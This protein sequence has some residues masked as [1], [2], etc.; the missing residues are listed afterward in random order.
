MYF[1]VAIKNV[2]KSMKDYSIYF[3]TLTIAVAIFYS[4][5]SIESQKALIEIKVSGKPYVEL[6]TQLI[7]LASIFVLIILTCL[8]VYA[9]NFLIKKR[10]KE[11]GIYMSLGMSKSKISKIL[12]FETLIIGIISLLF[13]ILLGIFI[14]Q[15]VS[16]IILNL[17]E[18][19]LKEFNFIISIPSIIKSIFSFSII[20]LLVMV[21]NIFIISKYKIIELINI[22]KKIE[23][24]KLKNPIIHL[25]IFIF[26]IICLFFAYKLIL[27]VGL[28]IENIKFKISIILGI[29]G[30]FLFFYSLSGIFLYIIKKSKFIYFKNL[31]IFLLK[32]I[33]SK[34]K[35]NFISMSI[36]CLMLFATIGVLS[37]GF[38]LKQAVES[39]LIDSTPF[40]A[41]A[42]IYI[43]KNDKIKDLKSVFNKLNFEFEK[44][45]KYVFF[46][47]YTNNK[48]IFEIIPT[49]SKK[50]H[51]NTIFL[52]ISEYNKIRKLNN[53]TPINL[54][55]NEILITSNFNNTLPFIKEYYKN[56]KYI[57]LGNENYEIKD[58]FNESL[59]TTG[60]KDN[61]CTIIINDDF[62]ENLDKVSSNINI[63]FANE[64]SKTEENLVKL[65]YNYS[66]LKLDYDT[67]GFLLGATK[68]LLYL[69]LKS[70]TSTVLF[71]GIYLGII[72]LISSMTILAL[73]QL[74]EANDS[75]NRYLTLKKIGANYKDIEKSIFFQTLIY[76][77]SP[78]FLAVIHS[79][80]GIKVINSLIIA[81]NKPDIAFPSIVTAIFLT[82]SFLI[83][84][85]TTYLSYKNIVIQK[86]K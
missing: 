9:N 40:D 28:E 73:Q 59:K 37:T 85:Y 14:S 78:I 26:C 16:L 63:N 55:K 68:N 31:N 57:K 84:F 79:I 34:I 52:K 71:L 46:E 25:F 8:I 1:D 86:I 20:F 2:R 21:F 5:N 62:C 39:G 13:G 33:N 58:I 65:L 38:S 19:D 32:Q 15:G 56:N 82:I 76:F 30:T 61:F 27:E 29:L 64:N 18:I 41:T 47:E 75:I 70:S 42:S 22:G 12:T 45:D 10:N 43:S 24:I 50:I 69:E 44:D 11:L 67:Y 77:I 81:Y 80:I 66:N 74:S 83:Y 17:F 36:I 49:I 35:T 60:I 4:F 3:L 7:S 54:E 48:E 53:K 72:F 23:R 51:S 6:L